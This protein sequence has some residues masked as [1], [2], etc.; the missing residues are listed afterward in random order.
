MGRHWE[1][2]GG[3]RTAPATGAA[4]RGGLAKKARRAQPPPPLWV[5]PNFRVLGFRVRVLRPLWFTAAV[6]SRVCHCCACVPPR[7]SC[8]VQGAPPVPLG[9]GPAA[10]LDPRSHRRPE[11]MTGPHRPCSSR[12]HLFAR[13]PGAGRLTA[14]GICWPLSLPMRPLASLSAPLTAPPCSPSRPA[15]TPVHTP[16]ACGGGGEARFLN[17]FVLEVL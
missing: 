14:H 17:V 13:C 6:A 3:K 4:G 10:G 1:E 9:L 7:T 12:Q 15:H 2:Q 11:S 8:S 5:C 16:R